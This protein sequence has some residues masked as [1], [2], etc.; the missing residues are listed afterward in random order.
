MRCWRPGWSPPTRGS[1][2]CDWLAERQILD[3]KGDWAAQAPDLAPGGWAFQYRND[4]YPDVDDTAVVG[5]LLHR[6]DS[7]RY[8]ENIARAARWIEGMQSANGGWGAFDKD[9]TADFLNSIPFADHGALL[10]PPTVDV[11]ADASPSM[12]DRPSRQ[13]SDGQPRHRFP[14]GRAGGGRLVVRPLGHQL[15]LWH[16]VGALRPQCRRRGH[17]G[18]VDP[19][20]RR[21]AH[22]PS[23][24]GWRMGRGQ[25]KLLAG[26]AQC[27]LSVHRI[28]D[29][30]GGSRA[31]GGRRGPD[32]RGRPR[33]APPS[34]GQALG[35]RWAEEQYTAV[36]FPR[37][38]YL[39]YHGY[40]AYSPP[41]RWGAMPA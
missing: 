15:C 32:R 12:P 29:G 41:G 4:F 40:S 18:A 27:R 37:V 38:F 16:L 35:A 36:G 31:D 1:S 28:P 3:V 19:A 13:P 8:H 34:G 10:D 30:L 7:A 14:Q 21:L 24:S 11:T 26:R 6:V 9:N 2:A 22:R 33:C 39:K 25:R 17:A 5:M 23:A 20:G